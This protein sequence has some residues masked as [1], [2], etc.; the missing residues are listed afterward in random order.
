MIRVSRDTIEKGIHSYLEQVEAGETVVIECQGKAIAEIR[1]LPSPATGK[2]P[3][4]L[5]AGE[6]EVP[7]D[8]DAP[9]PEEIL[10]DFEGR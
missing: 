9:L 5:C 8:F 10:G 1:P 3:F 6:F 2:R 4:G 7:D